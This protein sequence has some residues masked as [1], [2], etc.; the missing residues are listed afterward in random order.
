MVQMKKGGRT[1]HDVDQWVTVGMVLP[2][3][4]TR[5]VCSN[6]LLASW[7][8]QGAATVTKDQSSLDFARRLD[9]RGAGVGLEPS[10]G[11]AVEKMAAMALRRDC[12]SRSISALTASAS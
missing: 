12:A 8:A 3:S 4:N 2:P 5:V 10:S 9:V 1:T 7:P 11:L 6:E